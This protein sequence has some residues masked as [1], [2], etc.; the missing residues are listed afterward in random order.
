MGF[1]KKHGLDAKIIVI[2]N[3]SGGAIATAVLGNTADIGQN[4]IVTT[5]A[6]RERG[7]PM[8]ALFP[9]WYAKSSAVTTALVV[10][11]QSD[12]R[13]AGDLI[14]KTI[15]VPSLAGPNKLA[16]VAWLQK[17]NVD[18]KDV[19]FVEI[20][21]ITMSAA[22]QRGTIAAAVTSE[23]DLSGNSNQTRI[24][25]AVYDALG[26]SVLGGTWNAT[27]EWIRANP[28]TAGKFISAMSDATIWANDP[29]NHAASLKILEQ[30]TPYDAEQMKRMERMQRT[31]FGTEFDTSEMQPI[32]D[33]AFEQKFIPKP[34]RAQE[35]ISSIAP[36]RQHR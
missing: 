10:A 22:L 19:K 23:P 5:A 34:F 32:F 25:A 2:R 36:M 11:K 24:L 7:L 28:E 20:P 31:I 27:E 1:F 12:I 9:G 8:A 14:G 3:G 21:V 33:A 6:A 30:Y 17:S 26:Q 15:G 18:L 16:L 35:M 4:D 29:K 13:S